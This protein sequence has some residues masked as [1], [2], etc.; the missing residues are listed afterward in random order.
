LNPAR[1]PVNLSLVSL[2]S[3][4]RRLPALLRMLSAAALLLL[5]TIQ[6]ARQGPIRLEAPR[7]AVSRTQPETEGLI[8][9][10]A[11]VARRVPPCA[12]V[13]VLQ[14]KGVGYLTPTMVFLLAV[15]QLPNH[16]VLPADTLP[17]AAASADYVA[18]YVG[19]VDDS[20]LTP[21]AR[22]GNGA[23]YRGMP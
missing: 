2:S 20:G 7:T 17:A 12:S 15:G 4:R 10:L 8:L 1:P 21:V 19:N 18:L 11:E 13:A 14:G 22:I 23:L 5:A 9:F 6:I 3:V 16:R